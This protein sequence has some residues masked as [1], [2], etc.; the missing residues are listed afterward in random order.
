MDPFPARWEFKDHFR[1][2]CWTPVDDFGMVFIWLCCLGL[3]AVTNHTLRVSTKSHRTSSCMC[4][5]ES[6][7]F[8]V[9]KLYNIRVCTNSLVVKKKS[10]NFWSVENEVVEA[11]I[12][13]K[14]VCAGRLKICLW[15]AQYFFEISSKKIKGQVS[16]KLWFSSTY[17]LA[18][19]LIIT[20][21]SGHPESEPQ[22]RR[23]SK[24]FEDHC[25]MDLKRSVKIASISYI[26]S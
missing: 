2:A 12:H 11:P 1:F 22:E 4:P 7:G 18:S 25:K 13:N 15:K 21:D 10:F 6:V 17:W 23:L 9:L 20:L 16:Y 3:E 8:A 24:L 19:F 26:L 14:L 5:S